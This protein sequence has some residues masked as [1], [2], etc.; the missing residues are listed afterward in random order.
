MK[1]TIWDYLLALCIATCLAL[2]LVN[3]WSNWSYSQPC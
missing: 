3:W 1:E 2:A